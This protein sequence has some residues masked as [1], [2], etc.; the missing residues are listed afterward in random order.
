MTIAQIT[1]AL[2]SAVGLLIRWVFVFIFWKD[3][4]LD[5]FRDNIFT[6]RDDLF[7][8]AAHG[9]ISFEHPAY[10]MLRERMNLSLR[11]A[12]EFTLT[13]FFLALN[14]PSS[15]ES[16]IW[17]KAIESLS[18]DRREKLNGYRASFA[19]YALKYMVLRSFFLAILVLCAKVVHGFSELLKRRVATTKVVV[20]MERIESE[21]ISEYRDHD[22]NHKTQHPVAVGA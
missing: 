17:D 13:R 4:C 15:A 18:E 21:A 19:F 3:Y 9:N 14:L 5:I 22:H 7:L 10:R 6:L 11:F 2:E 1:V 16:A 8:Y 12:H 20:A